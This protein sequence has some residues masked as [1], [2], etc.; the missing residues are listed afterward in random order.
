MDADN[1]S[2]SQAPQAQAKIAKP[3]ALHAVK[4]MNDLLPPASAQWEWL[5]DKVRDLMRRFAYRNLR[6]SM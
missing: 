6:F 1:T 4:G 2:Q 3:V 5:E